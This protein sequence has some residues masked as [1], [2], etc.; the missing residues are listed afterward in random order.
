MIDPQLQG[1]TVLIT[2]ANHGIGEATASAF[3]AQG[4]KVFITYYREP[5]GYSRRSWRRLGRP[6]WGAE[7][8]TRP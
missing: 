1:K 3:A 2:G 5:S 7:R 4:S 6:A 8:C